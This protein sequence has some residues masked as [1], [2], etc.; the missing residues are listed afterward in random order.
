[1]DYQLQ[2]I[3]NSLNSFLNLLF[4]LYQIVIS[5]RPPLPASQS[6]RVLISSRPRVFLSPRPRV[7]K[8]PR[9]HFPPS[10]RPKVSASSFPRVPASFYLRVPASQ[11][12]R[13]LISPP[14]RVPPPRVPPSPRLLIPERLF[15]FQHMSNP[16]LGFRLL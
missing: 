6:L 14:P 3:S 12:L 4:S 8:S 7:P 11:S 9:P 2:S 1:M 10:P 5:P 16:F 15:S 13:V